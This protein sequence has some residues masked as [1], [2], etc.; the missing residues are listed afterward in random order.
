MTLIFDIVPS[1]LVQGHCTLKWLYP[2]ALLG[3]ISSQRRTRKLT[4]CLYRWCWMKTD[5]QTNHYRKPTGLGPDKYGTLTCKNDSLKIFLLTFNLVF[6]LSYRG[7]LEY[8]FYVL[9]NRK[10]LQV[11]IF[12]FTEYFMQVNSL[13]WL[14]FIALYI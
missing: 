7:L 10:L 13:Q 11:N 14:K 8:I 12:L 3:Y 6:T 5:K 1:I 2:E 9:I 4:I